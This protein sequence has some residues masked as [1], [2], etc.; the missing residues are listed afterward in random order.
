MLT[1]GG[2]N[3]GTVG[4]AG[5]SQLV[6]IFILQRRKPGCHEAETE[7]Q[8]TLQGH[9]ASLW[10]GQDF[11]PL[12]STQTPSKSPWALFHVSSQGHRNL[13]P[14]P[15]TSSRCSV[16][17]GVVSPAHLCSYHS[18]MEPKLKSDAIL[19]GRCLILSPQGWPPCFCS[20]PPLSDTYS[21]LL[22]HYLG[23]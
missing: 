6:S 5:Q 1:E 7:A 4:Q 12:S 8:V 21:F 13:L 3:P 16:D 23:T 10:T 9:T 17:P 15:V 2:Q 14:P 11:C 20:N 18:S 22:N 19:N